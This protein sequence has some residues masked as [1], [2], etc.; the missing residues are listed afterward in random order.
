MRITRRQLQNL[1]REACSLEPEEDSQEE[2]PLLP[3][4]EL[5]PEAE[6]PLDLP[7]ELPAPESAP[8]ADVPSPEDYQS[9]RNFLD[10]NPDLTDGALQGIMQAVGTSCERSTAQAVLDH[11]Q[12]LLSGA[13]PDQ[14][15]S[16]EADLQQQLSGLIGL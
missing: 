2:A 8:S 1:I 13:D 6:L 3:P 7:V 5:A 15:A 4:M 12:E 10:Q 11:L 9:T 16:V 14:A